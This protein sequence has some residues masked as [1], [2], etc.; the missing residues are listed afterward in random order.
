MNNES[1]KLKRIKREEGVAPNEEASSIEAL[2]RHVDDSDA[3]DSCDPSLATAAPPAAPFNVSSSSLNTSVDIVKSGDSAAA[4]VAKSCGDVAATSA[5]SPE[6]PDAVSSSQDP[7]ET[8]DG[9]AAFHFRFDCPVN[10]FEDHHG[11]S[12]NLF[13]PHC[14]CYVCNKPVP[15]CYKCMSFISLQVGDFV[16]VKNR[17]SFLRT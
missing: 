6:N 11:S 17:P 9:G 10:P 12:K 8:R 3:N 4:D 16:S 14:L 2:S 1:R 13:C 7:K 5:I 15:E